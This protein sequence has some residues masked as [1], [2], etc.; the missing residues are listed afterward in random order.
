MRFI[1]SD[2]KDSDYKDVDCIGTLVNVCEETNCP[3][4]LNKM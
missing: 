2:K 1:V 4:M 3:K